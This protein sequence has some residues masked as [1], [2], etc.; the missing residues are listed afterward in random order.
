MLLLQ[1]FPSMRI[2]VLIDIAFGR[3]NTT[4]TEPK[5]TNYL[6][7]NLMK[8]EATE[9]L[10]ST[11]TTDQTTSTTTDPTDD[12]LYY[13]QHLQQLQN[14]LQQI[15]ESSRYCN[16]I[17]LFDPINEPL[18]EKYALRIASN[19]FKYVYIIDLTKKTLC[20]CS[21]NFPH[22]SHY[23]AEILRNQFHYARF[24][25]H[26][27]Y[28]NVMKIY[29]TVFQLNKFIKSYQSI[30]FI[31]VNHGRELIMKCNAQFESE[32]I[33]WIEM[34]LSDYY[35]DE[36]TINQTTL[37]ATFKIPSD[38]T[39]VD[40]IP[41]SYVFQRI[42]TYLQHELLPPATSTPNTISNCQSP[43]LSPN[44]TTTTEESP[45]FFEPLESCNDIYELDKILSQYQEEVNVS[46]DSLIDTYNPQECMLWCE[47]GNVWMDIEEL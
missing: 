13:Q 33:V 43:D 7:E 28:L 34:E 1:F 47:G 10:S 26:R 40:F 22:L 36:C 16:P 2:I 14:C 37:P 6:Q 4:K 18:L 27:M 24:I 41:P 11:A 8:K 44:A 12:Q 42:I 19:P 38:Q 25:P 17:L 31:R 35:S 9:T 15:E 30:E 45:I 21:S 23:S 20:G 39:S 29:E 46:N 3:L 5:T 32:N